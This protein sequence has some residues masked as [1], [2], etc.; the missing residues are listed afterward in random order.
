MSQQSWMETLVEAQTGGPAVTATTSAL[1]LLPG[2]A[3]YTLPANYFFRPGKRLRITAGGTMSV[4]AT[5]TPGTLTWSVGFGTLAAPITVFTGG[6]MQLSTNILTSVTWRLECDL[7]CR[8][9]GSATGANMMGI[10]WALSQ[11]LAT[12]GV[13]PTM[14]PMPLGTVVVGTGFDS[15]ITNVVNLFGAWSSGAATQTSSI[16]LTDY[17][18]QSVN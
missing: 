3:V 18:L 13:I 1:S 2:A 12:A 6:A 4:L 8:A 10:G 9:I 5:T 7:T 11:A 15:T 14:N 16:T 17:V